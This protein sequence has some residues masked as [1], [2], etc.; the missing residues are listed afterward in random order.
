[1]III[2]EIGMYH[3]P[4]DWKSIDCSSYGEHV[5]PTD[6][7]L[8][9]QRSNSSKISF[10]PVDNKKTQL[11]SKNNFNITRLTY[12]DTGTYMCSVQ[13]LSSNNNYLEI[14]EIY[15]LIVVEGKV[16]SSHI[17]KNIIYY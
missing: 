1:M 2:N 6:V 7:V 10:P 17:N 12:N 8:L 14:F 3:I 9:F 11:I 13:V 4:G 16:L 15:K 5:I